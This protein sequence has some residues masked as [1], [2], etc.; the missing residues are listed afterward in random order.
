MAVCGV[1]A[2]RKNHHVIASRF[3]VDI[4]QA[5]GPILAKLEVSLGP[6]TAE[7]GIRIGLSSGPITAGVLR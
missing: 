7:L 1:P 5:C 6:D 4:L 3:A 2:K